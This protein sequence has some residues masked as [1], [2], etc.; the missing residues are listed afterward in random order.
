MVDRD[1]YVSFEVA[2]LARTKGFNVNC[3]FFYARIKFRTDMG[4]L[5]V[6]PWIDG[7]NNTEWDKER[8][9]IND[10][11]NISAPTKFVL[12]KWLLYNQHLQ[13]TIFSQSQESWQFKITKPHE[14]LEE[15]ELYG[16]Y[17]TKYEAWDDALKVALNM[18]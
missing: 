1:E 7:I 18:I 6:Y 17:G 16:D 8:D 10:Y 3:G 15:V 5:Q 9:S 14:T 12:D 13:I 11:D 2:E 4:N